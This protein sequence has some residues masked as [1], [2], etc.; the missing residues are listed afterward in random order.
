MVE[1]WNGGVVEWWWIG[2]MDY[3]G[4]PAVFHPSIL[5]FFHPSMLPVFPFVACRAMVSARSSRWGRC[6]SGNESIFRRSRWSLCWKLS[7]ASGCDSLS[8]RMTR[9]SPWEKDG[10]K[11]RRRPGASGGSAEIN[12][13]RSRAPTPRRR[14]LPRSRPRSPCRRRADPRPGGSTAP[15]S[16]APVRS[17]TRFPSWSRW[18]GPGKS[19]PG[20]RAAPR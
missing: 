15:L 2:I 4:V 10:K 20:S 13:S 6:A 8:V 18:A 17:C 3:R 19:A 1:H 11:H 14:P 16:A 5:P 9:F 12:I 7:P